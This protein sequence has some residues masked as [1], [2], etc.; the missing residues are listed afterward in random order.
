MMAYEEM[1]HGDASSYMVNGDSSQ[2]TKMSYIA[3]S[4]NTYAE[5]Y[6]IELYRTLRW[7]IKVDC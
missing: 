3:R 5:G 1:D 2:S 6:L 7:L 4:D